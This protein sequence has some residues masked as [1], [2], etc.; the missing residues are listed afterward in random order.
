MGLAKV[1]G[2]PEADPNDIRGISWMAK[3]AFVREFPEE[4]KVT[5]Q[6][7]KET[8]KFDDFALVRI[9][10]LSTM[11]CTPEFIGWLKSKKLDL[12]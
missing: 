7:I 12:S 6:E 8:G 10:R 11:S 4:Q 2:E 5:L 3:V 1:I 9:G